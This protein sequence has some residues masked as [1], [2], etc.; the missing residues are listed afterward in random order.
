M[1]YQISSAAFDDPH[2]RDLLKTLANYFHSQGID[3]YIVGAAARDIVL[4]MIH[5]KGARRKTNDLDIALMIRDWQV[6]EEINTS[7]CNLPDFAKSSRQKQRFHYKDHLILDV[8]PF[9]E[10]ASANR[11]IYWPPDETPVMSVSGFSEM[12]KQALTVTIDSEFEIGVASL[13]GIFVLKLI[14]WQDRY[15]TTNKD[16][17]DMAYILDEYFEINI[18]RIVDSHPD[19]FDAD[20]FTSFT[21]AAVLMGR[22]VRIL[23]SGNHDLLQELTRIIDDEIDKAQDSLLIGQI[24]ETHRSKKYDELYRSLKLFAREIKK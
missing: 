11:N 18:E 6:F 19:I 2:M 10:I 1:S 3:F 13:P 14:A 8:I 9:G 12:A 24:L 23:L 20:D 21:A 4:G 22:D 15:R 17:D 7:L 5:H 16:A